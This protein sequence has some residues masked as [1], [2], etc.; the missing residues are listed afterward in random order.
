ML[1]T[2][3][4]GGIEFDP[5]C[6]SPP[7]RGIRPCTPRTGAGGYVYGPGCS[8][9]HGHTILV[10]TGVGG[11]T[12]PAMSWYPAP[13]RLL[14]SLAESGTAPGDISAGCPL[15]EKAR[16]PLLLDHLFDHPDHPTRPVSIRPDP[17]PRLFHPTPP[18]ASAP[19]LWAS[20]HRDQSNHLGAWRRESRTD[21]PSTSP[22]GVR[23]RGGGA[24]RP[25]PAG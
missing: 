7:G 15:I 21:C 19:I 16:R 23:R 9:A 5:A 13:G 20:S 10:D 18:P 17:V 24:G 25:A 8:G 4:I 14:G 22:A 3:R 2:V 1:T 12:S 11:P 6:G